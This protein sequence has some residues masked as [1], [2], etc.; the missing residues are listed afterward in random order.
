MDREYIVIGDFNLYYPNW[1]NPERYIYYAIADRLLKLIGTK[2]I[3]IGLL[4]E[5]VT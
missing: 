5:S 1:N 2:E 4:G 3:E